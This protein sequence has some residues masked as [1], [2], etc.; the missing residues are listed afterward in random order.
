M[1][2]S[3]IVILLFCLTFFST[4]IAACTLIAG[5]PNIIEENQSK[6]F[7][8]IA[9]SLIFLA[10]NAVLFY[11]NKKRAGILPLIISI[12]IVG[13]S[14]LG[15]NTRGG[16]CGDSAVYLAKTAIS[17]TFVCVIAQFFIGFLERGATKIGLDKT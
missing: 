8:Y 13:L 5:G 17:I 6:V 9:I 15:S 11:L 16:D 2:I 7:V 10:A 1:K 4:D 14:L 12:A 3:K